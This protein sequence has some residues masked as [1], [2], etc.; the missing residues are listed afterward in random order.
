MSRFSLSPEPFEIAPLR[1][2]IEDARAGAFAAF[3]GRVRNHN[4]GRTVDALHYEAY[5]A[6]A[7][8][9]GERV[10]AEACAKFEILDACCVHRTGD[11]AIGDIAV[12]VGVAAAHR[13]AAFAACR[14]IIDEVKAR[15]PIWKRERYA[16]GDEDWLHP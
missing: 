4:D 12:W 2:A 13:D 14:Y 16:A 11:L 6:L 8:A 7:E 1:E 15:V 5:A 3:E 10:L 9:E